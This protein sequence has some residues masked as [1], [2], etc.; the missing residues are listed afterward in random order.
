MIDVT[1]FIPHGMVVA[2]GGIITYVWRD[3]TKR[4]DERFAEVKGDTDGLGEKLDEHFLALSGQLTNIA[5]QAGQNA[6]NAAATAVAARLAQEKSF[7]REDPR[8]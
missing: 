7:R 5:L 8:T 1:Q 2:L 6:A 4:D 3:H